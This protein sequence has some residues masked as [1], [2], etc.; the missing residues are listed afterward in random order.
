LAK[1]GFSANATNNTAFARCNA[2]IKMVES[3]AQ[4]L[5]D[6]KAA[7]LK[8]AQ[9]TMDVVNARLFTQKNPVGRILLGV[10]E[11]DLSG[12]IERQHDL[13]GYLKMVNMQLTVMSTLLPKEM[14][15]SIKIHDPY[16]QKLMPYDDN[17]DVLTFEGRQPSSTNFN[18]SKLYQVKMQ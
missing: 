8:M 17:S 16:T 1:I 11:P 6:A 7:D 5:D 9:E 15:V 4:S 12:Y 3:D 10:A 18:K 13:D 14:I 2:R